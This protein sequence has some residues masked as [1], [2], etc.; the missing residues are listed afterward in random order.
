[1]RRTFLPAVTAM[2]C[3]VA[4]PLHAHEEHRSKLDVV[5]DRVAPQ[6]AGLEVRIVDTLAP[7]MVISNRTGKTLE[8][9][10]A[11]GTPV[12]RIG[13]DRTWV[14]AS[15][16]AYYSEHPMGDHTTDAASK[17][18]RWVIASREPSWGWFDPR[19][20][21]GDADQPAHWHIDMR[22]GSQPVIVSGRFRTRLVSN[23]YWIPVMQTPSEIAPLVSVT[24]IPGVVPA[25]TVA[26]GGQEPVTVI[27]A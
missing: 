13:S 22:L 16:P 3:L 5:M 18:P 26:N 4:A 24:T 7:Q 23:G 15:A 8:I 20:Q 17:S 11:R 27:G 6:P 14:N 1:M 21:V 10:D 2:F 25:V 19:I 12:I 9:L